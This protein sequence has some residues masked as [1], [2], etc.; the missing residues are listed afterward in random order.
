MVSMDPFTV[1][2]EK[3]LQLAIP[4][5]KKIQVWSR[6]G[7]PVRKKPASTKKQLW[8]TLLYATLH[9]CIFCELF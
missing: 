2:S 4:E 8:E 3:G 7:V 1:I 5:K 6:L 9:Y